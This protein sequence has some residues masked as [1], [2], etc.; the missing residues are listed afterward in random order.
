MDVPDGYD[1]AGVVLWAGFWLGLGY[2]FSEAIEAVV[3]RVSALGRAAGY[4]VAGTLLA[5]VLVKYLRRWLFLRR[6]RIARIAPQELLRELEAGEDV[7]ILDL[8]T[9]LD[10]AAVPYAVRGGRW[11]PAEALDEHLAEIPGIAS[12]SST[13]PDP[14][15]PRAPG[16]RSSSSGGASPA[17]GPP[18]GGWRAGWPSAS[19]SASW[20]CPPSSRRGSEPG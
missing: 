12:W 9:A 8:R 17:C 11:I 13:A 2:V 19:R 5:Y 18:T 6:L 14:T 15:R 7:L 20:P 4:L 1:L 3:R 16:W 10:V